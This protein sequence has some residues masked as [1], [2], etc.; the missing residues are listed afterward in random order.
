MSSD[1]GFFRTR[2]GFV[3]AVFLAVAGLMLVYEHR[4]HISLGG[5]WGLI[6]LLGLCVGMHLLM[7]G[8]H[9]HSGHNHS[10]HDHRNEE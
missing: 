1:P 10:D 9:G 8:D 5:N 3:F 6:L 2:T 7:H 4:A